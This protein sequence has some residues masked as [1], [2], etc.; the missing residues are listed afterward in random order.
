MVGV[1]TRLGAPAAGGPTDR[2]GE[3][4]PSSTRV[5][6]LRRMGAPTPAPTAAVGGGVA[7]SGRGSPRR[8]Q[9]APHMSAGRDAGGLAGARGGV[10]GATCGRPRAGGCAGARG[11]G[12]LAGVCRALVAGREAGRGEGSDE[13]DAG[14][15]VAAAAAVVVAPV[16]APGGPGGGGGRLR[17]SRREGRRR[18]WWGRWGKGRGRRKVRNWQASIENAVADH[19]G[20]RDRYLA[21]TLTS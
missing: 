11:G 13:V 6:L 14:R 12:G 4:A 17:G 21:T 16:D 7:T 2:A 15:A 1:Q 8:G 18:S 20:N 10:A 19:R 9:E 3:A 5:L